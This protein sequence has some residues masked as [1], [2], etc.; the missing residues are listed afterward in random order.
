ME[1]SAGEL[2]TDMPVA[3]VL[4]VEKLVFVAKHEVTETSVSYSVVGQ[5]GYRRRTHPPV[6]HK[7]LQYLQAFLPSA[8]KINR[9]KMMS[10]NSQ[11]GLWSYDKRLVEAALLPEPPGPRPWVPNKTNITPITH[12]RLICG[13]KSA[14]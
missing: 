11:R 12:W 2:Q 3:S 14:K 9:I 7:H 6:E 13:D 8:K 5:S 10:I 4:E 1:N